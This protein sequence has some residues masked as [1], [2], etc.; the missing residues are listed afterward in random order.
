MN[1]AILWT[2]AV[3]AAVLVILEA[4]FLLLPGRPSAAPTVDLRV[5]IQTLEQRAEELKFAYDRL[6]TEFRRY[7]QRAPSPSRQI[8]TETIVT[9]L[10]RLGDEIATIKRAIVRNPDEALAIPSMA[11]D[12]EK[13][14]HRMDE[15][16]EN[17]ERREGIPARRYRRLLGLLIAN[18]LL[19]LAILARTG[20]RPGPDPTPK[21]S[22]QETG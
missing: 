5:S 20:R 8:G 10:D 13:L 11:L 18:G 7:I 17:W 22:G 21:E 16:L 12:I 15:I 2:M 6:E 19:T 1:R 4:G 3:A 9:E 14:H